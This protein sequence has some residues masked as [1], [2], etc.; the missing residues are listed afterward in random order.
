MLG[1]AIFP[2][3]EALWSL[4]CPE[5]N[6]AGEKQI[7]WQALTLSPYLTHPAV[8]PLALACE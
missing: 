3:S 4:V 6:G 2:G 5:R 1:L 7:R 8:L